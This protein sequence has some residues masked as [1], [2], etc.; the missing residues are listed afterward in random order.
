[1]DFEEVDPNLGSWQD[2]E[3]IGESYQL[4]F[5][6]VLNHISSK[7]RAFQEFLNGD[8]LY[9]GIAISYDSPDTLTA[10][11]RRML[12]RPRTSDI[13]SEYQSIHGPV[14]VWTTFS[15]D[16]IDL[17]YKNPAVLIYI[18]ETM[19]LYVRRGADILRLDAVTYLWAEPGTPSV[20]LEQ[21]HEIIKLLR[22]VMDAVAPWVSL[23]TETNVPHAENVSYFGNGSDEAHIVYNFAL[24]PLVL[25]AFYREDATYL[26]KWAQELEYVSNTTTFLNMLDTHDG[27]GLMGA[28]NIL[29][30]E[31]IDFLIDKAKEHGAFIS[32]KTEGDADKP[33]EVNTT[34]YSALNM[35]DGGEEL[36]YQVK[37]YVAS[38]SIALALRG[39]PAIYFHGLIGT[40]NDIEAVL[41]TKSKRDINR[42][43]LR[44]EDLHDELKDSHSKFFQIVQSLLR[45]AEIRV[46]QPAFHPNGEQRV[47]M[48]SPQIFSVFRTSPSGKHHVL[49]MTNVTNRPCEVSIYMPDLGCEENHWYD[50]VGR[51]GR[52]A[53]EGKLQLI[54]EPYDVMWLTPF[55]ELEREI[56]SK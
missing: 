14:H 16:Q 42:K 38:R 8:P 20:H 28:R 23:L 49:A 33:Y 52:M 39:V 47:M 13:L 29:P 6:G 1:M 12:V 54:L 53:Q 34:W 50:L 17:N 36:A 7:S 43:V 31:E 4:M 15:A 55:A 46:R 22:D 44:E 32:Y 40:R 24:P 26:S 5:D 48:L 30:I 41:R 45:T 56:E 2:I 3:E 25:H 11:Q 51:R 18:I 21:T 10:E 27:V 35:D 9:R 37:R 19:L